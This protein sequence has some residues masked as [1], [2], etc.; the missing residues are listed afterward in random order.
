MQPNYVF[1]T[2]DAEGGIT[3]CRYVEPSRLRRQP[4]VKIFRFF[5][6]SKMLSVFIVALA[7]PRS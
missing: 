2:S 5:H 6:L 7:L 4:W 3:V 1:D